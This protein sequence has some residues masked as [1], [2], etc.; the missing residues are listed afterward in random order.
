MASY[1]CQQCL[2]DLVLTRLKRSNGFWCPNNSNHDPR[3]HPPIIITRWPHNRAALTHSKSPLPRDRH[4]G[5]E[6]FVAQ[7]EAALLAICEALEAADDFK[8]ARRR[9]WRALDGLPI[10]WRLEDAS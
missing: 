2:H 6:E 9:K 3:E 8:R 10:G 1:L 5:A 4:K 7:V